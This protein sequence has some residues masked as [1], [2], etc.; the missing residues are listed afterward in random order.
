MVRCREQRRPKP[1]IPLHSYRESLQIR[2]RSSIVRSIG[3]AVAAHCTS[4]TGVKLFRFSGGVL[5]NVAGLNFMQATPTVRSPQSSRPV[6]GCWMVH[7]PRYEW[8]P[9]ERLEP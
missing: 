3:T 6:H 2:W 8:R 7:Q 5:K 1:A 9:D 4:T